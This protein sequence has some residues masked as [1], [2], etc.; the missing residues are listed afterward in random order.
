M[1]TV[2]GNIGLTIKWG[3]DPRPT[4]RGFILQHV[5]ITDPDMHWPDYTE[6]WP[7]ARMVGLGIIGYQ[8]RIIFV[9]R[10][11]I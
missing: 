10:K 5:D 4:N 9:L 1:A 3:L 11:V 6:A 2:E 8:I 7:V